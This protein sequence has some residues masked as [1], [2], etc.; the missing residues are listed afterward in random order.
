MPRTKILI[1]H[2]VFLLVVLQSCGLV[3]LKNVQQPMALVQWLSSLLFYTMDFVF[4]FISF[5]FF[6]AKKRNR[7]S[8]PLGLRRKDPKTQSLK[9]SLCLWVSATLCL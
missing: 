7:K 9:V 2:K 5:L 3:D 8:S 4:E 6:T 1:K